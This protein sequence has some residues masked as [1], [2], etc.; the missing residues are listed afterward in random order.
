[1]S[2]PVVMLTTGAR[3]DIGRYLAEHHAAKGCVVVGWKCDRG[4]RGGRR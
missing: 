2:D 1:M 3:K 4:S